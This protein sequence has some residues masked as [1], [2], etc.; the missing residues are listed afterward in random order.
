VTATRDLLDRVFREESGLV[1]GALVA[2]LHDLDRAEEAFQDAVASALEHW[3]S[4][5]IPRRPGAWLLVAARRKALDSL[6]RAATRARKGPELE[7]EA[8]RTAP[9]P[10]ADDAEEI[11]DE[12][13]RLV[14]TCCH[15]VLS[16]SAQVALT[17][18]TLGGLTTGEIARAFLVDESAMARRLVRAKAKLREARVPYRVP[19]AA[20]L[21]ERRDS[22]LAVL[23]LVFNEGYAASAGDALVRRELCGEAI[24]LARVLT[25]LLPGDAEARGLAAL[26]L[27]VDARREAR[28]RDGVAVTLEEQD[29]GR[30]DRSQLAEGRALLAGLAA[31]RAGPYEL[32]ARIA[33]AHVAPERFEDTDWP[34]IVALYDRLLARQPSPVVAMNR[35]VAVGFAFGLDAA[36]RLLADPGIAKDLGDYLPY[37]AARADLLR[38]AGRTA[39]ARAAYRA[40]LERAGS[41]PER[42]FL[43]SRLAALAE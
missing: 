13:L 25:R 36:L 4:Q 5:G 43:E 6:R 24:R 31:E 40:A 42:A 2:E 9:P 12:R 23:Y 28:V 34:A 30:W 27:L 32:Q 21:A 22:V 41:A 17:L 7:R 33:A 16:R 37:H 39:E 1:L 15:P 20:E 35:A 14:F 38:R 11:P 8:E 10:D 26:L 18:R 29:R 3:P 19:P